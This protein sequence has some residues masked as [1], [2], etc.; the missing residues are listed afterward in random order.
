MDRTSLT[1]GVLPDIHK[2]SYEAMNKFYAKYPP[3]YKQIADVAPID[4]V[5]GE[6][7]LETTAMSI[8]DIPV[9]AENES[10]ANANFTEGFSPQIAVRNRAVKIPITHEAKRDFTKATNFLRMSV[11]QNIPELYTI[12]VNKIVSDQFNYGAF[13]A[14]RDIFNQ[15]TANQ[16]DSTGNFNYD[17]VGSNTPFISVSGVSGS[18]HVNQAGTTYYNGLAAAVLNYENL[19]TANTLLVATNALREDDQPFDNT[20]DLQL[21]VH[22]AYQT[23]AI[24]T[25]KSDLTPDDANT[26]KSAFTNGYNII[27]NPY[28]RTATSWLIGRAGFGIKLFLGKP[29]Y[30]YW[31]D[32]ETLEY[33]ASVNFDYA[34]GPTNFRFCVGVGLANS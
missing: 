5:Q 8:S 23:R 3:L 32:E 17:D 14:G 11:E 24:T 4:K 15:S 25:V 30:A 12:V 34:C 6:Y 10:V 28:L 18:G 33:K 9:R 27:V 2:W 13:T 20:R 22:P 29:Q 7:Y 1:R 31:K 21:M 26:G 16:S 19:D